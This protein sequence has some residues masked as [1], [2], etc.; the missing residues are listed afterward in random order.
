[1]SKDFG[2]IADTMGEPFE[3]AEKSHDIGENVINTLFKHDMLY[4]LDDDGEIDKLG[5]ELQSLLKQTAKTKA[6]DDLSDALR[7]AVVKI[8]WDFNSVKLNIGEEPRVEELFDKAP[9]TWTKEDL[10]AMAL[11]ERRGVI[12]RKEPEGWE[13]EAAEIEFWNDQYGN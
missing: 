4:L 11:A 3:K 9:G 7:Y 13:E 6:K 10:A 8:P 1:V 12:H 2:T 5:I